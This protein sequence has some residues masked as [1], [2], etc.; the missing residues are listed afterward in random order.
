MTVLDWSAFQCKYAYPSPCQMDYDRVLELY[1]N[2]EIDGVIARVARGKYPDV[3]FPE[4]HANLTERGV[5][6]AG[7]GVFNP[8][9]VVSVQVEA[10]KATEALYPLVKVGSIKRAGDVELVHPEIN[11]PTYAFMLKAYLEGIGADTIYSSKYYW[12]LLVG[13]FTDSWHGAYQ[14]WPANYTNADEPLLPVGWDSY[15]LWQYSETG[16]GAY[17]GVGS[18]HVDLNRWHPSVVIDPPPVPEP[19]EDCDPIP[20]VVNADAWLR[21]KTLVTSTYPPTGTRVQVITK[22]TPVLIYAELPPAGGFDWDLVR[23][24]SLGLHGVMAAHLVTEVE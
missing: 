24:P 17:Y 3:R 22:G 18:T 2:G 16:D 9:Q 11:K 8:F 5:P 19:C 23:V 12:E 4:F 14:K 21:T 20:G 7:Y 1:L 15:L 10:F 13:S 6:L